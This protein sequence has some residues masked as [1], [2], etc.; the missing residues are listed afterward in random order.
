MFI[1]SIKHAQNTFNLLPIQNISWLSDQQHPLLVWEP[2]LFGVVFHLCKVCSY[3]HR[4]CFLSC[5]CCF[6]F[7]YW[8]SSLQFWRLVPTKLRF[9]FAKR[10]VTYKYMKLIKDNIV[11]VNKVGVH[12]VFT[13]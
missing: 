2:F 6:V 12:H 10:T 5:S 13:I 11:A 9:F 7:A 3:D 4:L 8:R 1:R